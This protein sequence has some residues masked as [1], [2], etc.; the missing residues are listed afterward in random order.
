MRRTIL[1][2]AG[3]LGVLFSNLALAD[4]Q[5]LDLLHLERD[6][7]GARKESLMLAAEIEQ[8]ASP[9]FELVWR[10]ARVHCWEADLAN[11]SLASE[12]AKQHAQR[13][14]DLGDAAA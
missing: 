3:T 13:C 4:A 9:P 11:R 2:C 8:S 5:R 12:A 7:A 1:T 10:A 14:W 6:D